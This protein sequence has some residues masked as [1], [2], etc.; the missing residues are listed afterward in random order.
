MK[1]LLLFLSS[2]LLF[3]GVI[4]CQNTNS[5]NDDQLVVG[6]EAAYA[7]FNWTVSSGAQSDLAY[8]LDGSNNYV[9]GYDVQIAKLIAKELNKTL[10]IK[11]VEWEG[12]VPSL[13]NTKDIDLIIAGMSPTAYRAETVNFTDA[14]Y[15][16]THVVVLRK[17]SPFVN[18]ESINDFT[19]ASIVGQ[20]TTIYDSLI[21]Q[22]I[23]ARHANP[24]GD[25]PT[26]ITGINNSRYDATILELPVAIAVC[27]SNSNLTYIEFTLDNGFN[28]SY[29]DKVVSI[30]L[31][32]SDE[33]LLTLINS[34]LNN[35]SN[36]D[37]ENIMLD[38]IGRQP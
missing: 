13:S 24:L 30:A 32:K 38:A 28:V 36:D 34:V 25:V 18:A 9:D 14:Y 15:S 21:D 10:V 5:Q 16:S 2:I 8:P 37:R 35:L 29:E 33:D 6:M 12:L 3:I 11:A 26:I 7:P 27:E 23:G 20:I 31:R 19:G 1:K 17:D 4:S 22:M